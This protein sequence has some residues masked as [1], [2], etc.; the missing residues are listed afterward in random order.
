MNTIKRI[1]IPVDFSDSSIAAIN[2]ALGMTQSDRSI[3][4][5]LVHAC[6][7]GDVSDICEADLKSLIKERFEPENVECDFIFK[8]GDIPDLLIQAYENKKID[9]VV[10]GTSGAPGEEMQSNT[11]DL[12]KAADCSVL[13]VPE[14][15][16]GFVLKNI[17]LAIDK[18]E[19][20]DPTSLGILHD[21][22]RW[23][24][25]KVHLL[26]I[27]QDVEPHEIILGENERTLEYYMG[28]L[29]YS[30]SF[31]RN[32]DIEQG[33]NDYVRDKSIDVLAILPKHHAK[34][35]PPSEGKLT[36][37]LAG[38]SDVPLLIID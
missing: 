34:K 36:K 4:F 13:V 25:A 3:K 18:Q 17:A 5:T 8:K 2:Y 15:N 9:L 27:D 23:Y 28:N 30:R 26:T 37:I 33:L 19:I 12:L 21:F 7:E 38:H 16:K 35:T 32:T 31:P 22:A 11:I 6:K 1:L 14:K 24:N 29:D 20:D 10:M